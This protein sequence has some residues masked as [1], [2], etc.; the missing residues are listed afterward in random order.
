MQLFRRIQDRILHGP[1][2]NSMAKRIRWVYSI[3]LLLVLVGLVMQA[4]DL[5]GLAWQLEINTATNEFVDGIREIRRIEKNWFLSKKS[6]DLLS[7][8]EASGRFLRTL[9]NHRE[10]YREVSPEVLL[11]DIEKEARS[12]RSLLESVSP[13]DKNESFSS[14]LRNSG[15]TLAG[16]VQQFQNVEQASIQARIET[17]TWNAL[18][19][20][21]LMIFTVFLLGRLL[22]RSVVQPLSRIVDYT[23]QISLENY[24]EGWRESDIQ[25]VDSLIR[26]LNRMVKRIKE[27]KSRYA[28]IRKWPPWELWWPGSPTN[29]TIPFPIY[30]VRPRFYSKKA[31]SPIFRRNRS[32]LQ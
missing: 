31:K 14:S 21:I 9:E 25:E 27:K 1:A 28:S 16:L 17:M 15:R 22:I 19:T 6:G 18:A 32:F 20:A 3:I 29:S 23:E 8:K 24:Q 26:S 30:P 12:Y 7:L 5:R 11:D 2:L 4:L 10:D 13:G